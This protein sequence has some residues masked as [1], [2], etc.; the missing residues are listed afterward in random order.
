MNGGLSS[1]VTASRTRGNS[2]DILRDERGVLE[3]I[4]GARGVCGG[5]GS[6]DCVQNERKL[7]G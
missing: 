6:V 5:P 7:G 1:R 3:W 4:P 2:I